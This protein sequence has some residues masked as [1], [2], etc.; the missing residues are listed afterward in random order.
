[1]ARFLFRNP[2][3]PAES[4]L[5]APSLSTTIPD[6]L[7][8]AAKNHR[9]SCSGGCWEMGG[10]SAAEEADDRKQQQ[11]AV[12]RFKTARSPAESVDKPP[13]RISKIYRTMGQVEILEPTGD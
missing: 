6:L 13:P 9:V 11:Y 5:T 7:T 8:T 12:I 4:L 2:T 1:M 3:P 10:G